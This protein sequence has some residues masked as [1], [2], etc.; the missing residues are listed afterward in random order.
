MN[1]P[2]NL[3]ECR[4]CSSAGKLRRSISVSELLTWYSKRLGL[5]FTENEI[6]T[7]FPPVDLCEYQC[8]RCLFRW[9]SPPECGNGDYYDLLQSRS[10]SYYKD[11][12]EF[13]PALD[14]LK[15]FKAKRVLEIGC[16]DGR[17]LEMGVNEGLE[18]EGTELSA[19]AR[20]KVQKRGMKVS[21]PEEI[22]MREFDAVCMF[23]VLEHLLD[24]VAFLNEV[25]ENHQ[26]DRLLLAT[27]CVESSVSWSD[28]PLY[29]PPHHI[30]N[31][32]AKAYEALAAKIG[33]SVTRYLYEPGHP[34]EMIYDAYQYI[35]RNVRYH[36]SE[37][38]R[39]SRFKRL[40]QIQ[41]RLAREKGAAWTLAGHTIMVCLEKKTDKK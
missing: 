10:Q 7:H 14:L 22:G 9:Y 20:E 17:F 32:S 37:L 41:F 34:F 5:T 15:E 12:W 33:Y 16:G 30:S 11:S 21:R 40:A 36:S 23:Q 38:P 27:P 1:S 25:V 31:W 39:L 2:R 35:R 13:Q 26:P 8:D 18:M 28:R 4:L 6:K 29:W 24:P 19:L 3:K